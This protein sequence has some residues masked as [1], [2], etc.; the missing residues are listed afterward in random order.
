M[1][2]GYFQYVLSQ[3]LHQNVAQCNIRREFPRMFIV[4]HETYLIGTFKWRHAN[5][6]AHI[7][8][9]CEKTSSTRLGNQLLSLNKFMTWVAVILPKNVSMYSME[10]D[11]LC[12]CGKNSRYFPLLGKPTQKIFQNFHE[13]QDFH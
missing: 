2:F 7:D 9:D 1:Y 13:K 8:R 3:L 11:C 6:Y 10:I 5:I 4:P 12:F